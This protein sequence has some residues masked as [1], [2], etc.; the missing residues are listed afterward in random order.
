MS[1]EVIRSELLRIMQNNG[2]ML[3]AVDVVK[4]AKSE[5]SPLHK[6]FEWDD[7]EAATKWREEQARNLIR[8]VKITVLNEKPVE[9][10]AFVSLASD[11]VSGAGYR[12]IEEVLN[13]EFMRRQLADEMANTAEKWAERAAFIGIEIDF[14]P[15]KSIAEKLAAA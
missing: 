1:N 14:R 10:R 6:H 5:S 8:S 11:R 15:I 3:S 7:T 2:G 12:H 9:F 4:E 13:N